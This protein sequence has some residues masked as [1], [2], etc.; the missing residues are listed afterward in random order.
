M[1][2]KTTFGGNRYRGT[3]YVVLLD[4]EP[5]DGHLGGSLAVNPHLRCPRRGR[6]LKPILHGESRW[7]TVKFHPLPHESGYRVSGDRVVEQPETITYKERNLLRS[8][9]IRKLHTERLLTLGPKNNPGDHLTSGPVRPSLGKVG[10]Y[11]LTFLRVTTTK[12]PTFSTDWKSLQELRRSGGKVHIFY[13]RDYGTS[14]LTT[15]LI[16]FIT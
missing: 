10:V 8:R 2:T 9:V 1:S 14:T 4:H 11:Y 15:L 13:F 3:T 16:N 5:R 6:Y 7:Y 12:L